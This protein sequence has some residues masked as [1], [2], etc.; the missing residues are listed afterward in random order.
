MNEIERETARKIRADLDKAGSFS[1]SQVEFI[2]DML[3]DVEEERNKLAESDLAHQNLKK[4]YKSLANALADKAIEVE[5]LELEI[6]THTK[7]FGSEPHDS[8]YPD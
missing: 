1:D 5:R 3:D 2:L 6:D 7:L 4:S 8:E